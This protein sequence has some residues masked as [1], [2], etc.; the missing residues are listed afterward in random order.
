MKVLHLVG[1]DL[2][3]KKIMLNIGEKEFK[4]RYL[5]KPELKPFFAL[6]FEKASEDSV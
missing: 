1:E 5:L 3:I 6:A 2:D 4:N